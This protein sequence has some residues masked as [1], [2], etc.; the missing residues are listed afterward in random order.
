MFASKDKF[1][2]KVFGLKLNG[3]AV[4]VRLAPAISYFEDMNIPGADFY[5]IN[6]VRA[7]VDYKLKEVKLKLRE[8]V[9]YIQFNFFRRG[10]DERVKEG[11]MA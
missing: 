7:I 6:H 8:R 3:R 1:L 4:S 9:R 11:G 5:A 2:P 10:I